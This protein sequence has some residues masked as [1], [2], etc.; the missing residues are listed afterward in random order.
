MFALFKLLHFGCTFGSWLQ[1]TAL[2]VVLC[3]AQCAQPRYLLSLHVSLYNIYPQGYVGHTVW[4]HLKSSVLTDLGCR[5][6][7][8]LYLGT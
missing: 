4:L 7:P 3:V 5:K 1:I 8:D 2:C 6:L